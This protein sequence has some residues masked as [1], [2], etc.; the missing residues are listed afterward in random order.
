MGVSTPVKVEVEFP[1]NVYRALETISR[2]YREPIE[3]IV[4][5][6][7]V[8]MIQADIDSGFERYMEELRKEFKDILAN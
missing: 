2:I 5:E 6:Y 4:V 8:G 3:S 1:E 7:V